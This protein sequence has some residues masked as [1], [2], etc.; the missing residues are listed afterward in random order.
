MFSKVLLAT[1]LSK[2]SS[3]AV[4]CA[5]GLIPLGTKEIVLTECL[6]TLEAAS[7]VFA[8]DVQSLNAILE[9]QKSILEKQGFKV[10]TEEVFGAA[11]V[12]IN[13]LL[14]EYSCDAV[15]V[16]SLGHS[17]LHDITLG[18]LA[19]DL[20]HHLTKPLLLVRLKVVDS[21]NEKEKQCMVAS[22]CEDFHSS[23]LFPTDFSEHADKA[24]LYVE[25]MVKDG[26]KEVTIIHIQD[27]IILAKASQEDLKEYDTIDFRRLNELK[28]RLLKI[29][30]SVKVNTK[31]VYGKPSNEI[32]KNIDVVK[33]SLVVLGTHGRGFVGDL[34]VG[35][36]SHSVLRHAKS[37][38]LVIP[39]EK[40][41]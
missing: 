10:K 6:K 12:E 31:I 39:M 18:S 34:F 9:E 29:S 22:S 8:E 25:K 26:A 3:E 20:I 7:L 32:L 27:M 17:L 24:F 4:N 16:P 14:H 21:K 11:H 2:G 15:M 38:V 35:S 1:D 40:G 19:G 13:R 36:V 5:K 37:T 28:E 23:I 33:P 41:K 30:D